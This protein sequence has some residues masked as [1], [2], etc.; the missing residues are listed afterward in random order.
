MQAIL[1]HSL[2]KV[3]DDYCLCKGAK[4]GHLFLEEYFFILK[5]EKIFKINRATTDAYLF[6][7]VRIFLLRR[8]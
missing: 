5:A 4:D 3:V 1:I 6:I 2:S 8:A 7:A